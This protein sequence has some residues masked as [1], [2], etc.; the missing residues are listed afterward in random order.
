MPGLWKRAP[1]TI[2]STTGDMLPTELKWRE[3]DEDSDPSFC[4]SL[5][6]ESSK[7]KYS[8]LGQI[9]SLVPFTKN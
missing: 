6:S 2:S 9:S 3:A 7:Q 4:L 1:N 5:Q 8:H